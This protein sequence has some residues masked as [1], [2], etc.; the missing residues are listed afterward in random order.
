MSPAS[1][2]QIS[3]LK[4]IVWQK[5]QMIIY[6][7]NWNRA[8]FINKIVIPSALKEEKTMESLTVDEASACI[9][10]VQ[11]MQKEIEKTFFDHILPQ[12]RNN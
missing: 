12:F 10:H 6:R 4:S 11:Q 2:K 3:F 9:Q 1:E 7:N 8:L 5:F